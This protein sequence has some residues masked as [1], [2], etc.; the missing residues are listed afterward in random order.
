MYRSALLV[1]T[2]SVAGLAGAAD[3]PPAAD[4]EVSYEK[5]IL[6][7]FEARCIEC[8]G[9]EKMKS[10]FRMDTPELFLKGGIEGTPFVAGDSAGSF[11]VELLAGLRD[12]YDI[13]PPE[14]EPLTPEQI[15]LV[16]AWIDQ[17]AK[18][19][20]GP[21]MVAADEPVAGNHPEQGS[22]EGL[23]ADWVVEATAQQGPLA[24]WELRPEGVAGPNGE[25]AIALTAANHDHPGTFNLLWS[26]KRQFTNGTISVMVKDLSG[27][28]D[29]GGGLM[30]RV[31]DKNNYYVAR[32]NPLEKNYRFYVVKDG[33]RSKIASADFETE[34]GAWT[35]IKIEQNGANFV[36]YLNGEKLLEATD[37]TFA[38]P[39]GIG[40]WT[41]ADAATAF[42]GA[43]I[44]D[45]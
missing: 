39:G 26:A 34:D 35:T 32:Y 42:A 9:P 10:K 29:R 17:G 28:E 40:Y 14:G 23:P 31:Q 4:R 2:M 43:D 38:G 1:L 16:R 21:V 7:I 36:G 22:V 19:A 3:L 45:K 30:W 18:F 11:L 5:D 27:E 20:G 37:E 25:V 8:H 12:D 33:E 15:G 41:K 24:T 13:M 44:E 6:P